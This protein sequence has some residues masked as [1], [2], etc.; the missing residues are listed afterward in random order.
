[1]LSIF[2]LFKDNLNQFKNNLKLYS[3]DHSRYGVV[4]L[5]IDLM[6]L[7]ICS[8]LGVDF[9]K[10]VILE[11]IFTGATSLILSVRETFKTIRH[12]ILFN[13]VKSIQKLFHTELREIARGKRE[14]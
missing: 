9:F 4:I 8:L 10:V 11:T 7:F 12:L 1:M 6:V 14:S 3:W 13:A 2:R 5:A